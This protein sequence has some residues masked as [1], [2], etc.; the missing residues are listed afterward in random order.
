MLMIRPEEPGDRE[1]VQEV[2]LFAF[3]SDLEARIVDGVREMGEP[4]ISLVAELDGR[5]IGHILFSPVEIDGTG[6]GL[7]FAG[8]AP[9]AVRPEH[10]RRGIGSLLVQ[11]GLDACRAAGTRLV[12]VLGHR[13]YY[14]RFGFVPARGHGLHFTAPELDAYFFVLEL[15]PGALGDVSGRVAYHELFLQE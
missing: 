12:F 15:V 9:M 4:F 13:D 8:L 6:A 14:P 10:Q 5:V 7:V 1:A 3:D 11:Q 2:N